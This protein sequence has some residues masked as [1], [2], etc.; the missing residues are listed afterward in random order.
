MDKDETMLLVDPE[1]R[2]IQQVTVE[3]A[4]TADKLFDNLMGDAVVPR[5][6]FIQEHSAEATFQI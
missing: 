3:D 2:N 5:K 4:K 1:Q 6:K